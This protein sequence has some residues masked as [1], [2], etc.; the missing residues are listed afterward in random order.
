MSFLSRIEE[1]LL[2]SIWKLGDN[3]FGIS[4]IEQVEKDTNSQWRSGSIYGA[5]N[6]LK[7]NDLIAISRMEQSPERVGHPRIYYKL[8]GIGMEKLIAAQKVAQSIWLGV[9]DLEKA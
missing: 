2:L 6:R 1:I 9:P 8:T 3:A 7:K 5:L 4:I